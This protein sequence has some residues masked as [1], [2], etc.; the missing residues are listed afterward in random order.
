VLR[1]CRVWVEDNYTAHATEAL[2]SHHAQFLVH[3]V[4]PQDRVPD[5]LYVDLCTIVLVMPIEDEAP[6]P[7]S[8]PLLSR[9]ANPSSSRRISSTTGST[10]SMTC[11]STISN[12]WRAAS[13][14]I[15]ARGCAHKLY[16]Y[17]FALV[18]HGNVYSRE[19]SPMTGPLEE[20]VLPLD[21][22]RTLRNGLYFFDRD[23]P[24][25]SIQNL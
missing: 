4:V 21:T 16:V 15:K 6:C 8:S 12:R 18:D 11:R 14:Y 17:E 7:T 25:S 22:I 20:M 5:D 23:P 2:A 19:G 9:A 24:M 3:G 10:I 1:A 13:T